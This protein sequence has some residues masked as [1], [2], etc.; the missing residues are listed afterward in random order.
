MMM[1]IKLGPRFKHE[2][3]QLRTDIR[4]EDFL[5]IVSEKF[6]TF[7]L[8]EAARLRGIEFGDGFLEGFIAGQELRI[9]YDTAREQSINQKHEE[10]YERWGFFRT[11]TILEHDDDYQ[12]SKDNLAEHGKTES[13]FNRKFGWFGDR[14][15]MLYT[16][17]SL[18][19]G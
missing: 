13:I 18:C 4:I 7:E 1:T 16:Y 19:G 8:C 11:H 5:S 2:L 15:Y 6:E 12:L 3:D 14:T 17:L 10:L 9:K